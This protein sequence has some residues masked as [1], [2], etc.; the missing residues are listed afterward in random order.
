MAENAKR[1]RVT[2]H[3]PLITIF[4]MIAIP[5]VTFLYTHAPTYLRDSY[6][7]ILITSPFNIAY[8]I[9]GLGFFWNYMFIVLAYFFI[10]FYSRNLADIRG[11]DSLIDNAFMFSVLSAY[12]TSAIVWLLVGAPSVGTSVIGF[13]VFIFFAFE[14][15]D[16]ELIDRISEN[17]KIVALAAI[18]IFAFVAIVIAWSMLLFVY[19]NGNPDWYVHLIGGA[20]F[21]MLFST[22]VKWLRLRIDTEEERI[23][24][25]VEKDMAIAEKD[26]VYDV[27]EAEKDIKDEVEKVEKGKKSS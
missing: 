7:V 14:T 22:Y 15:M 3:L 26:I 4:V 2:L 25:T 8:E 12:I 9:S 11:R 6:A 5:L 13:T 27:E 1:A 19:L 18:A 20:I 24:E 21:A 16:S 10:E 17:K 23:K